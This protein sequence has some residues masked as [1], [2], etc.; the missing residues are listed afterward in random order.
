MDVYNQLLGNYISYERLYA[1]SSR[2]LYGES[3]DKGELN[4][5]IDMQSF[6]KNMWN[7][8]PYDYKD[9]TVVTASIVNACAHYRNYFW[10][11]HMCKTNI[12]VIWGENTQPYFPYPNY[13]IHFLQQVSMARA[14]NVSP[15]IHLIDAAKSGLEFLCKYLPQIYYVDGDLNEVSVTIYNLVANGMVKQGI[16]NI[17]LSKDVYAYQLVTNLQSTF[18][19]RPKKKYIN[20]ELVDQSWVVTKKNV[21]KAYRY[22]MDYVPSLTKDPEWF[23]FNNVLALSGM[24]KRHVKGFYR[25]NRACEIINNIRQTLPPSSKVDIHGLDVGLATSHGYKTVSSEGLSVIDIDNI[26]NVVIN[27]RMM[28]NTPSF[29]KIKEGLVDLYNPQGVMEIGD[30]EFISYPLELGEL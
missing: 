11:R 14:A 16:P 13:N 2:A 28:M 24:T 10:T 25:F 5:F 30:K 12:Y 3:I 17:I 15:T 9:D 22:A 26:L 19:Y 6:T 4:L 18:V 29:I 20:N 21:M 23:E 7:P 8:V 27:A 1:M